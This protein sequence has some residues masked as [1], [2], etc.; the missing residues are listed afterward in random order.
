MD[1]TLKS[2]VSDNKNYNAGFPE[3]VPFG[4]NRWRIIIATELQRTDALK[5]SDLK[6]NSHQ[7]NEVR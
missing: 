6:N 5:K 3:K 1:F 7:F 2:N 4:W